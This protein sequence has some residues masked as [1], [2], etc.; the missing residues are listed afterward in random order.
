MRLIADDEQQRHAVAHDHKQPDLLVRGAVVEDLAQRP[1]RRDDR[2]EEDHQTVQAVHVRVGAAQLLH[3]V[4]QVHPQVPV[5]G[6]LVR[7]APL[8]QGAL[9]AGRQRLAGRPER[10]AIDVPQ[11]AEAVQHRNDVIVG[12]RV[13]EL[14]VRLQIELGQH[15]GDR[16][17]PRH[18]AQR[19]RQRVQVGEH[20][21]SAGHAQ[22]LQLVVRPHV[23]ELGHLGAVAPRGQRQQEVRQQDA[24]E[25]DAVHH[26]VEVL[27]GDVEEVVD[28]LV[29]DDHDDHRLDAVDA[30]GPEE[31]ARAPAEGGARQVGACA[32]RIVSGQSGSVCKHTHTR[33]AH[34][35]NSTLMYIG[36]CFYTGGHNVLQ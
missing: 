4:A 26:F 13:P 6:Q 22:E 30:V 33:G 8:L 32:A 24:D 23:L 28:A 7:T 3:H 19:P 18:E 15:H 1:E 11:A 25:D 20:N 35:C 21:R 12:E 16:H 27:V 2:G 29:G 36:S 5:L 14:E 17:A 10:R 31:G 34:I 9:H